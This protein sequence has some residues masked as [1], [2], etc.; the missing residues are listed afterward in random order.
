MKVIND[1][2][3]GVV[4][5]EEVGALVICRAHR[6]AEGRDSTDRGRRGDRVVERADHV[7]GGDVAGAVALDYAEAAFADR[8]RI[9]AGAVPQVRG[10]GREAFDLDRPEARSELRSRS[11]PRD[12]WRM[13]ARLPAATVRRLPWLRV[14]SFSYVLPKH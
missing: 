6:A 10:V 1:D 13:P 12:T 2:L 4:A 14:N 7:A 8:C 11:V 5:V 9:R 3:T